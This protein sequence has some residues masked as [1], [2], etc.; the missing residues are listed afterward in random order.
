[1]VDQRMDRVH[2]HGARFAPPPSLLDTSVLSFVDRAGSPSLSLTVAQEA[3]VGGAPALKVYVEEQ[4]RAAQQAVPGYAA[5][6]RDQRTVGGAAAWL[7]EGT[8]PSPGKKR[9]VIQLYVLDAPHAC[10]FVVTA[11]AAA[12]DAAH[13]RAAVEHIAAGFTL[14]GGA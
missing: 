12:S 10:V 14:E 5:I 4:Q 6:A 3:L 8:A 9:V 13:A 2:F 11:T 1:M 7:V